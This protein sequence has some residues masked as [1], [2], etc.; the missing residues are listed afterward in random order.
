METIT[1]ILFNSYGLFRAHCTVCKSENS[2]LGTIFAVSEGYTAITKHAGR[3]K[4]VAALETRQADPRP[5][6][7]Q[8]QQDIHEGVDNLKKKNDEKEKD[9][10]AGIMPI[11]TC[12][13]KLQ[14][15]KYA[16]LSRKGFC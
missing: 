11:I 10:V 14:F 3:G 8:R 5:Q 13:T 12:P 1:I 2:P 4:H 16:L 6:P 9:G 7:V 15:D